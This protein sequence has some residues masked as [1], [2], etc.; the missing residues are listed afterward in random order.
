M[1]ATVGDRV[2]RVVA[3]LSSAGRPV[4]DGHT[5]AADLGLDSLDIACLEIALEEEF[6]F[7]IE[8]RLDIPKGATVGQAVG[9]VEIALV[10][11]AHA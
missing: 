1:T 10:R 3:E 9:I 4:V 11:K 7:T 2:R 6:G 8:D 5:L